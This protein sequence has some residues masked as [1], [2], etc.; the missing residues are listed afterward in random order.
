MEIEVIWY[1]MLCKWVCDILKDCGA[2][3]SGSDDLVGNCL[4]CDTASHPRRLESN[5]TPL[6]EPQI[7][8]KFRANP[9]S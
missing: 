4:P 8:Q 1:A 5:A 6:W 7:L 9:H 2:F 3:I